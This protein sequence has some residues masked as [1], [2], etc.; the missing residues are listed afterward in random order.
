MVTRLL[1]DDL[2]KRRRN[3]LLVILG[4]SIVL[5]IAA[6]A[7]WR[8]ASPLSTSYSCSWRGKEA[9]AAAEQY[10]R[11]NIKTAAAYSVQTYDCEEYG[12]AFLRFESDDAQ[13]Q[14][15]DTLLKSDDCS[16][17]LDRKDQTVESILCS[18]IPFDFYYALTS[19]DDKGTVGEVYVS[20]N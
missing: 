8:L 3:R 12:S 16:A 2:M 6:V 14:V 13:A 18:T 5:T 20:W 9:F 1:R 11:E 4:V 17:V 15:R 19:V 7:F 10:T